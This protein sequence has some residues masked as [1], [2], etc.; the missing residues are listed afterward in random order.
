M[1]PFKE[2]VNDLHRSTNYLDLDEDSWYFVRS[3]F[4]DDPDPLDLFNDDQDS[5]DLDVTI[6]NTS[7]VDTKTD[8]TILNGKG[9][10]VASDLV[11]STNDSVR[12]Q[13][14]V[15]AGVR[16]L[17]SGGAHSPAGC[18]S[19]D[20]IDPFE[21]SL[22]LAP[23]N[24]SFDSVAEEVTATTQLATDKDSS[25]HLDLEDAVSVN[26]S[27]ALAN[28]CMGANLEPMLGTSEV[29]KGVDMSRIARHKTT[30][31]HQG[32]FEGEASVST[33]MYTL[34]KKGIKN[35]LL[36]DGNSAEFI[37]F[38]PSVIRAIATLVKN[39]SS[40]NLTSVEGK[41]LQ[42]LL[43]FM[44]NL[45]GDYTSVMAVMSNP[46]DAI[47]DELD[48]EVAN[49]SNIDIAG[50]IANNAELQSMLSFKEI[51]IA[52]ALFSDPLETWE[53]VNW[54][55]PTFN[56]DTIQFIVKALRGLQLQ[57]ELAKFRNA[58]KGLVSNEVSPENFH[59]AFLD[60]KANACFLG[61]TAESTVPAS[62]K[63]SEINRQLQPLTLYL[64]LRDSEQI[65]PTC[66]FTDSST[67]VSISHSWCEA[68]D[69]TLRI[70]VEVDKQPLNCALFS[71]LSEL[72]KTSVVLEGR[73]R[74]AALKSL[75]L[76]TLITVDRVPDP[77]DWIKNAEI[78][79]P[80][81]EDLLRRHALEGQRT[82][83]ASRFSRSMGMFNTVVKH[84]S[85]ER[86]ST[87]DKNNLGRMV[88]I[89]GYSEKILL[90]AIRKASNLLTKSE[91]IIHL[92]KLPIATMDLPMVITCILESHPHTPLSE[93]T[94][95]WMDISKTSNNLMT[96]D[97]V[98][99]QRY[100]LIASVFAVLFSPH[101]KP[102][103]P[104]RAS[105]N[106]VLQYHAWP[107]LGKDKSGKDESIP[108]Y[109]LN[110][111]NLRRLEEAI[112]NQAVETSLVMHTAYPPALVGDLEIG[113]DN[114]DLMYKLE[115]MEKVEDCR[116]FLAKHLIGMKMSE[117]SGRALDFASQQGER[118]EQSQEKKRQLHSNP[119]DGRAGVDGVDR[120]TS[121]LV[122]MS[123]DA[124]A[125]NHLA[126]ATEGVQASDEDRGDEPDEEKPRQ[127]REA[128]TD[129]NVGDLD[130]GH[131][132]DRNQACNAGAADSSDEDEKSSNG[133]KHNDHCSS[134]SSDSIPDLE[135]IS[136]DSSGSSSSME[137]GNQNMPQ[138]LQGK[139]S[140][141]DSNDSSV[142]SQE[143]LNMFGHEISGSESED[144]KEQQAGTKR[145]IS[146]TREGSGTSSLS[147]EEAS[148]FRRIYVDQRTGLSTYVESGH[149]KPAVTSKQTAKRGKMVHPHEGL[150]PEG[151]HLQQ[152]PRQPASIGVGITGKYNVLYADNTRRV[153]G[154]EVSLIPETQ[155]LRPFI[156]GKTAAVINVYLPS[157]QPGKFGESF[158]GI[159]LK[160]FVIETISERRIWREVTGEAVRLL[161]H[162]RSRLVH[163][164]SIKSRDL[165][166]QGTFDESLA[167][168]VLEREGSKR[169]EVHDF[170]KEVPDWCTP[171]REFDKESQRQ[172]EAVLKLFSKRIIVDHHMKESMTGESGSIKARG[173]VV[174]TVLSKHPTENLTKN[175][176]EK[177]VRDSLDNLREQVHIVTSTGNPYQH[178]DRV[179][180]HALHVTE[181]DISFVASWESLFFAMPR[182]PQGWQRRSKRTLMPV[183]KNLVP[184]LVQF[185]ADNAQW[186]G[187]A[188]INPN[189]K[190]GMFQEFTIGERLVYKHK[191]NL[192]VVTDDKITRY[193]ISEEVPFRV[194]NSI[195]IEGRYGN[196]IISLSPPD[197]FMP[198]D[199][200][201]KAQL[202]EAQAQYE[203]LLESDLASNPLYRRTQ[204]QELALQ[205]KLYSIESRVALFVKWLQHHIRTGLIL[206][207]RQLQFYKLS[208][209]CFWVSNSLQYAEQPL[210]STICNGD[211]MIPTC[212]ELTSQHVI[213][214]EY[215]DQ[216]TTMSVKVRDLW[217]YINR[218]TRR[219]FLELGWGIEDDG[220]SDSS[221]ENIDQH[222]EATGQEEEEKEN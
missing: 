14:H 62:I 134:K 117:L 88:K 164:F 68:A 74:L 150:N 43:Q 180:E 171:D 139:D 84:A 91:P 48:K 153:T 86:H 64:Y 5:L 217:R 59:K 101:S 95:V 160:T 219:C 46:S 131:K 2:D 18:A 38:K 90:P 107:T 103:T 102:H 22:L 15:K 79:S 92:A 60:F 66:S 141:S 123:R 201:P 113:D 33:M 34:I 94:N 23:F 65:P 184:Y 61:V 169:Y 24:S 124:S 28:S 200:S 195:R 222:N 125:G 207:E 173:R 121:F 72:R 188:F 159:P 32:L 75:T 193:F 170:N 83:P 209:G 183:N 3:L 211:M 17:I 158:V 142:L 143:R 192:S 186:I 155:A 162:D 157:D 54:K 8:V 36:E 98:L 104:F 161:L 63:D 130:D 110:T 156:Q 216:E 105:L 148:M 166:D 53:L 27:L 57:N 108:V 12:E 176:H 168:R 189:D 96:E 190:G 218:E 135:T 118:E 194:P 129:G 51:A 199:D 76:L 163:I 167:A 37:W 6:N 56:L 197:F 149:L 29:L 132:G 55:T 7:C 115:N 47:F 77:T 40:P 4:E 152:L 196:T 119:R 10:A 100:D 97:P 114:L 16:H 99:L 69:L 206:P 19:G 212:F 78:P 80:N 112:L 109:A 71:Q 126:S 154:A 41:D 49:D 202:N 89:L 26:S 205:R 93:L 20:S 21:Q 213:P 146:E 144:D 221:Q 185:A 208:E 42:Q 182:G 203:Y 35:E 39:K 9:I 215:D 73:N 128:D 181:G 45:K 220:S 120:L 145:T 1:T 178:R 116:R 198:R 137:E 179:P 147:S 136:S 175:D 81:V 204:D 122:D 85:V 165:F 11:L 67:G 111:L 31:M 13:V 214:I 174:V 106:R 50:A 82:R 25:T 87:S 138:G 187:I 191:S 58:L 140:D 127:H 210:N 44:A 52:V 177:I 151:T 70:M 30:T 172:T 133:D